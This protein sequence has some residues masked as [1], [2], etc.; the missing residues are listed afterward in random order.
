VAHRDIK[1]EN[2]IVVT[3]IGPKGPKFKPIIVDFGLSKIFLHQERSFER[4]GS[5]LFSSPEILLHGYSHGYGTDVWSAGVLLHV[6]LAGSFPFICLP[7]SR[8]EI[9]KCIVEG[10]IDYNNPMFRGVSRLARDLL[11]RMLQVDESQ[12][13]TIEQA[14][15]HPWFTRVYNL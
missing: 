15:T 14:L 8:E 13:I 2:V 11:F 7:P 4:V 1:L 12:R 10:R 5:L 6:L 3:S 9:F